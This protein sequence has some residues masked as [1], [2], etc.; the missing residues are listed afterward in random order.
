MNWAGLSVL[1][2]LVTIA[3]AAPWWVSVGA[4][5]AVATW[6]LLRSA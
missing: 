5:A 1:A 4:L 2:G 6:A 3:A